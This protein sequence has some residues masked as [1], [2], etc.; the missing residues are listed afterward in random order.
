MRQDSEEKDVTIE[1]LSGEQAS[2]P[3][4][5]ETLLRAPPPELNLGPELKDLTDEIGEKFG[6]PTE[7]TLLVML[8]MTAAH[9]GGSTRLGSTGD[10]GLP[11]NLRTAVCSRG[12]RSL[13]LLFRTLGK[14]IYEAER[15]FL[16]LNIRRKG[17]PWPDENHFAL[18]KEYL[19]TMPE[20]RTK[21]FLTQ[22]A[23]RMHALQR[24]EKPHL[25]FDQG[26]PS[27]LAE[28]LA[29]SADS[30]ILL[31]SDQ[32]L[33]LRDYLTNFS[34]AERADFLT[35]MRRASELSPI[36]TPGRRNSE[37]SYS[38]TPLASVLWVADYPTLSAAFQDD[39]MVES[40]FWNEF[41]ILDVRDFP[42]LET[43]RPGVTLKS[44]PAWQESMDIA[45]RARKAGTTLITPKKEAQEELLKFESE[46][47]E[48]L[49]L[50]DVG[51]RPFVSKWLITAQK[52]AVNLQLAIYGSGSELYPESVESGIALARWLG[53]RTLRLQR[54]A[55]R[56]QFQQ[57]NIKSEQTMLMKIRVKGAVDFRNLCR[58]YRKQGKDLHAPVL[59]SLLNKGLIRVGEDD[60]IRLAA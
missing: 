8:V 15:D 7:L 46:L 10:F 60:L 34:V 2:M 42:E 16:N 24:V 27:D 6:L 32:A 22:T 53:A 21:E 31:L 50:L 20:E 51:L 33:P 36:K 12:H 28:Q 11:A 13:A 19:D 52:L 56:S 3:R 55:V 9:A 1:M 37:W 54:H 4:S 39:A 57:E 49:P 41:L 14:R 45:F 38:A 17:K 47:L 35:V 18:K 48:L 30:G 25:I 40:G 43:F 59:E 58:S 29:A 26:S 23:E 44:L 5:L